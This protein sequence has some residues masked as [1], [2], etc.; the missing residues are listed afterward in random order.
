[1]DV[2]VA[3]AVDE[4]GGG[5]LVTAEDIEQVDEAVVFAFEGDAVTAEKGFIDGES[6]FFGFA[7]EEFV[8]GSADEGLVVVAAVQVVKDLEGIEEL[9]EVIAVAVLKKQVI[10]TSASSL[11]DIIHSKRGINTFIRFGFLPLP[12]EGE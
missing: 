6:R 1:M 3:L 7:L 4:G 9:I 2:V 10:K 5:F 12:G 11:Q 8:N